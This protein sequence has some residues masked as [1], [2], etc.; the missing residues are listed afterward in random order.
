MEENKKRTCKKHD[1]GYLHTCLIDMHRQSN[2]S[3]NFFKNIKK[4]RV[5]CFQANVLIDL[6]L[7]ECYGNSKKYR[8]IGEYPTL[9]TVALIKKAFDN[10]NNECEKST[11]TDFDVLSRFV[12][13]NTNSMIKTTTPTVTLT[14]DVKKT[15]M[16]QN[17]IEIAIFAFN[18]LKMDVKTIEDFVSDITSLDNNITYK[19]IKSL[20]TKY[21]L[22]ADEQVKL[23]DKYLT[24]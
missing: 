15:E 22:N 11:T 13:S 5:S 12:V 16:N 20:S 23:M 17:S 2:T 21:K 6:N 14:K 7:I 19:Q 3:P 24:E 9:E 4:Y 8:W 1:L 10:K 18:D